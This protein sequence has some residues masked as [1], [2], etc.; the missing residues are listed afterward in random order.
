MEEPG[1]RQVAVAAERLAH[2]LARIVV[3][4]DNEDQHRE[5]RQERPQM[6]VFGGR[7]VINEIAGDDGHIG[8]RRQS[9]G[10]SCD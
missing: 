3:A 1:A 10:E 6:F 4:G 5:R 7:A 8:S 9:T 2:A